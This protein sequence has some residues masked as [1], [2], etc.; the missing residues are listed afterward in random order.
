LRAGLKED[1]EPGVLLIDLRRVAEVRGDIAKVAK[2]AGVENESL[3]GAL[4]PCR[5]A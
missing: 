2:T 5:S 4:S 1:D 3:Y